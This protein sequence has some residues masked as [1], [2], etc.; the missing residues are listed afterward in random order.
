M[1]PTQ[2]RF[3]WINGFRGKDFQKLVNQKQELPVVAIFVD[4]S[5][6][7]EQSLQTTFHR[8][9]LPSFGSFGQTV[10]EEK[11]FKNQTIR[12]KYRLWWPCF[13]TDQDKMSSLHRGPAIDA[14]YQVSDHLAKR[15]QRRRFLEIDKSETR[16]ACGSHVCSW[17][18]VK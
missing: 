17:I 5:G 16:I 18:G 15:F 1:L 8:C 11:N 3:I 7:N 2:F 10:S 13:L 12:N 14:F 9:F 6:Q 4:G